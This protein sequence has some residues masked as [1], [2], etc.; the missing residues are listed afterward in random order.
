MADIY[1]DYI[2]IFPKKL[3]DEIKEKAKDKRLTSSQV[4]KVLE[5]V[6]ERYE[7][8]LIS[9]GEAIGVVTAE[10]IG[11]PSTQ[12][13][14]RTFHFSGVAEMNVTV[15]LPRLIEIFDAR[16]TPSTPRMEVYLK[17]KYSHDPKMVR[18]IALQIKETKLKE[19][20]TEF[21]INLAKA[22]VEIKLDH[23]KMRDILLKEET[24]IAILT[25]GTKNVAIKMERDNLVFYPKL[26]EYDLGEVFK[27]KEKVKDSYIC[28]V[29]GITQVL[30]FKK[31]NEFII[32][33]AG[34]NLKDMLKLEEVDEKRT[35]TNDIKEIE[36]V[37]GIE[38]AR[39]SIINESL[40][41]I[42]DQGLDIDIRHLMFLADVM[43]V[44]GKVKGI[45][46][47]GITSEKQ[48]V[49]ARASFETPIKHIINA[50]LTG[51]RDNL[52][53]VVENVMVNQPVPLGTGM[54]SLVIKGKM[55]K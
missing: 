11:E 35:V 49:L 10:S 1:E 18:K 54:A 34:T 42:E 5:K 8:S 4:K 15:G 51:E 3:I 47:S 17:S 40:K 7:N 12:M 27:L 22:S 2:P 30:P 16:K 55:K 19:I 24:L 31:D 14:L 29:K 43:T 50:A 23:K 36:S 46:R 53:S 41:V 28:G 13:I 48:S 21:S 38:A 52:N 20:A 33:C 45:T 6:K 26:K 44:T 32:L 9:P 25:Q 37:L 39:Q